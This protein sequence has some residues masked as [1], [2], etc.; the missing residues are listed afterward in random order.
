LAK[1][2]E[3][4]LPDFEEAFAQVNAFYESLPWDQYVSQ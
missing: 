1:E 2:I 4:E 3:G